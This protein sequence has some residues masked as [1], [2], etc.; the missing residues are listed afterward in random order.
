MGPP[1]LAETSKA[2]RRNSRLPEVLD[3]LFDEPAFTVRRVQKRLGSTFRGAQLLVDE[4]IE[5][6]IVREATNRALDRVFVAV[7]LMP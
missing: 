4:L 6:G 1:S 7:D 2:K 3:F 5:A